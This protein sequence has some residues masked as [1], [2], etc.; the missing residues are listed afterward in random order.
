MLVA[1][2]HFLGLGAIGR[3][4]S[5]ETDASGVLLRQT[6]MLRQ[7]MWWGKTHDVWGE[8]K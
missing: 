4:T 1:S 6:H 5:A 8:Y 2:C 3:V 7:G